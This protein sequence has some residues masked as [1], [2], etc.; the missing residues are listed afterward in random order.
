MTDRREFQKE[1]LKII[2]GDNEMKERKPD[3]DRKE[4]TKEMP[5]KKQVAIS[6]L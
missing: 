5:R 2:K 4:D 3:V 6:R 1:R